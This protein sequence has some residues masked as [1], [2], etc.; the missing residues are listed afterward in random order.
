MMWFIMVSELVCSFSEKSEL[1]NHLLKKA[2]RQA[3]ACALKKCDEHK[4]ELTSVLFAFGVLP[5]NSAL[6]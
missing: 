4:H 6:L 2:L 5:K 3:L 1:D